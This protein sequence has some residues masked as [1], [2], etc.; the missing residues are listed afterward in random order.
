VTESRK[1][2]PMPGTTRAAPPRAPSGLPPRPASGL[3]PRPASG[4][5]PR[6]ASARPPLSLTARPLALS[7]PVERPKSFPS[8]DAPPT[9]SDETIPKPMAMSSSQG[10]PPS[11]TTL[12]DGAFALLPEDEASDDSES[13]TTELEGP[14]TMMSR[15]PMDLDSNSGISHGGFTEQ[16]AAP[17]LRHQDNAGAVG[18]ESVAKLPSYRPRVETADEFE[19]PPRY[20]PEEDLVWRPGGAGPWEPRPKAASFEDKEF[21]VLA[22]ETSL[23]RSKVMASM[24]SIEITGD[25]FGAR[26]A[27]RTLPVVVAAVLLALIFVAGVVF[28]SR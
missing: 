10:M 16:M 11:V 2:P 7:K 26:G 27:R 19:P 13:R 14:T 3:P 20:I 5:P 18:T 24:P 17:V 4:L 23:S 22:N 6:P 8:V 9:L 12:E 28:L 21:A 1:P 25:P 15:P